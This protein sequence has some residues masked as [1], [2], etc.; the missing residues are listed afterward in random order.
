MKNLIFVMVLA[1]IPINASAFGWFLL[2]MAVAGS[3][4]DNNSKP[5]D[6]GNIFIEVYDRNCSGKAFMINAAKIG[7]MKPIDEIKVKGGLFGKSM[8]VNYTKVHTN[9][10]AFC[11][12][13][14]YEEVKKS[15][16]KMNK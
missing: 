12:K 6:S 10:G 8:R 15:L 3:G 7:Y 5:Q 4:D 9:D 14:S 11:I 2:G 13:E 16:L 1:L